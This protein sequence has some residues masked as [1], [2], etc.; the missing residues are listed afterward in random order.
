MFS[1]WLFSIF[2][3]LVTEWSWNLRI[4]ILNP[5][6]RT[7]GYVSEAYT[8]L[9]DPLFFAP[10]L[11]SGIDFFERRRKTMLL[12]H[13]TCCTLYLPIYLFVK[14]PE[15]ISAFQCGHVVNTD[16]RHTPVFLFS[17]LF[18]SPPFDIL[19]SIQCLPCQ[20]NEKTTLFMKHVIGRAPP[21]TRFL[22]FS[23]RSD[24]QTTK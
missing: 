5:R 13:I 18:S 16:T 11:V 19:C 7:W 15:S 24:T 21:S 1:S 8:S 6:R 12:F 17:I 9:P 14:M 20:I 3:S 23:I 4:G 22:F 10:R 2:T